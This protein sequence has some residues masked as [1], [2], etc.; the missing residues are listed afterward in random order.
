ME[1]YK[2]RVEIGCYTK[3]SELKGISSVKEYIDEANK[4]GWKAIG[5]SDINSVQAFIEAQ[6]YLEKD[7]E[8]KLKIIYG[9]K[10]RFIDDENLNDI[11][12]I[13]I[14]VKEQKGLKNL[15]SI[16]SNAFS[17]KPEGEYLI[18]RSQLDKYREGLL[19][20]TFGLNGELFKK[21]Y[22]KEDEEKLDEVIK[23]YDFIQIE[24]TYN[25]KKQDRRP[26]VIGVR[27]IDETTK[28]QEINKKLI[29]FGE[30]NNVLVVAS[31]NPLF[32]D[33]EDCICNEILN[34]SKGILDCEYNNERYLH[35]TEEMLE[36]FNYID[37]EKAQ[38]IVVDNTNI[39]ADMCEEIK[40]ISRIK[41]DERY[42]LVENS[43]E[44]IK[45][46]CCKNVHKI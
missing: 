33:K 1:K 22:N 25:A 28:L 9:V 20:G 44:I 46:E 34:H 45:D 23:Y 13:T 14:L 8:N 42:P 2:E 31:S 7:E 30:K 16:L 6:E 10:A 3:M 24:P 12:D 4:R 29:E 41:F 35:T 15:Y 32:V 37:K 26:H 21:L 18:Y 39:L 19:Y 27:I 43:K 5:I 38:K 11:N 36:K 17:N 40:P